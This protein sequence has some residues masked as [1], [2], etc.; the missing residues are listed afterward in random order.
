MTLGTPTNAVLGGASVH[1]LTI[2]DNDALPT[3][4]FE[5]VSQSVNEDAG[6]VTL[7]VELSAASSFE[8]IVPFTIG[9]T[10]NSSD[11]AVAASSV[12]IPAGQTTGT[13]TI[14]VEN[15]SLDENDETVIVTLGT[16]THA[17]LGTNSTHTLTI[18]DDDTNAAPTIPAGQVF[19]VAEN[20]AANATVGIVSASDNE[21]DALSFSI[22]MG[23]PSNPFTI[24][25]A[26]GQ[27]SVSST[28]PSLDFELTPTYVLQ[29]QVTDTANNTSLQSVTVNLTDVAEAPV[30]VGGGAVVTYFKKNRQPVSLFPQ[31][32]ISSTGAP[33]S[34]RKL[35]ISYSVPRGGSAADV[36]TNFTP[37]GQVEV[38]GPLDFRRQPG[39]RTLTVTFNADITIAQVQDAIRGIKFA[40]KKLDTKNRSLNRTIS[41][42]VVDDQG[43]SSNTVTNQIRAIA[44]AT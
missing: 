35:I 42:H 27:L 41:L 29:V 37:L 14:N 7:T 33:T 8:V 44:K 39:T 19:S 15:D 9:G 26:T 43:N 28:G 1:T 38:S 23:E 18:A 22:L 5:S 12:V 30:I 34:L 6:T 10:A 13:I 3:V 36:V 24:D 2:Q 4:S 40:T 32:T 20:S 25:T 16:P 31:L 17:T 11:F 21:N